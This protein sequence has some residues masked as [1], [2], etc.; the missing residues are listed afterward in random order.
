MEFQNL[1]DFFDG[2]KK[3]I[4]GSYKLE[5]NKFLI[6]T[7]STNAKLKI[8]DDVIRCELLMMNEISNMFFYTF[9]ICSIEKMYMNIESLEYIVTQCKIIYEK[10]LFQLRLPYLDLYEGISEITL[11]SNKDEKSV[12]TYILNENILRDVCSWMDQRF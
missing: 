1:N 9:G 3:N 8:H 2:M 11:V 10:Y 5:Y 4:I 12:L 7:I 6:L